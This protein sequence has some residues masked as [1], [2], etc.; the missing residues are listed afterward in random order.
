MQTRIYVT[1][2]YCVLTDWELMPLGLVYVCMY[3]FV[4]VC[5]G[6]E[7]RNNERKKGKGET[8]VEKRW[9]RKMMKFGKIT[10]GYVGRGVGMPSENFNLPFLILKVRCP[11]IS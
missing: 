11:V 6:W 4:W 5:E 10:A 1:V 7:V 2:N 8:R 9:R 3:V